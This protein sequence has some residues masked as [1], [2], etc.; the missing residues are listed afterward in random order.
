[1]IDHV[2][3]IAAA[4][5]SDALV[6]VFMAKSFSFGDAK[7]LLHDVAQLQNR[8]RRA[9]AKADQFK[10]AIVS[11]ADEMKSAE[12]TKALLELPVEDLN[13]SKKG[14]RT[15]LLR[16][17][18]Y[19]SIAHVCKAST[20]NLSSIY[21]I[22][23][24][25]ARDMKK[26]AAEYAR[27][28]Q[29]GVRIRLTSDS[30][31]REST[32]LVHAVAVYR[33][34]VS[35]TR[36]IDDNSSVNSSKI[37]YAQSDLSS[38]IGVRWLLSSK[39]KKARAEEAYATLREAYLGS[40]GGIQRSILKKL[41]EADEM[42]VESA[43]K[44]FE[45]DPVGF[46]NTIEKI[47]PGF[48]GSDKLMGYGLPEDLAL[49]IQ[50]ECF[51]PDGLLVELRNYQEWGVKY[52]LHQG[53]ALLGDEMGLGKTV[54]AIATM[55]SLKNT[56]ATHFVVVCPASVVANWC[57]EIA[58]K[59]RLRV[60]KVH[61]AKR[62]AALSSWL[63]NGGVAVTTYETTEHF[64]LRDSFRFSLLVVDEAH[65]VKNPGARRSCNVAKLSEHAD[66][67]LF[68]TGTALENNVEEMVSLI[69]L[70]RPDIA[71][72]IVG[73]THISSAARFKE[74]IAPVYYRRK[75]DDV[76]SELPELIESED[77]CS[78]SPEEES[79]YEETIRSRNMMAARR[80]SWNVEDVRK[81][82]KAQRLREIIQEGKED[83]RKMLVFSYFLDTLEKAMRAA[84]E[85]CY[86]PI[87]GSTPPQRRQEIIDE[88]DRAPAGSV[89]VA[90]IQSGGT[91]LN[92]QSASV[93]VICEPQFK[94]S[95]ENQAIS[96]AYRMGQTRNVMVHRLLC[97]DSVDERIVEILDE[98]RKLFAAFA[99]ESVAAKESLA[100]DDKEC[101]N[102]IEKEIERINAKQNGIS[103][104]GDL[105]KTPEKEK[106][107]DEKVCKEVLDFPGVSTPSISSV[108]GRSRER[109]ALERETNSSAGV[110]SGASVTRRVREYPQ[111]RGG[112]LNPRLF[113]MVQLGEGISELAPY[114][115]VVPGLVG[116]AVDY[117][118][119]FCTGAPARNAFEISHKG[120]VCVGRAYLF[121]DLVSR[122]AGL[123]DESIVSA[124]RLAAFDVAYRVG[125]RS[126]KPVEEIRPDSETIEN[127][128][129]MVKRSCRFL[130]DYG[131]KILD[132]L[133]FEGGYTDIVSASDGDFMTSDALWDFKVSKIPLNSNQTLQLLMY[134]RMGLHSIHPEFQQVKYL[135]IFNP[136]M[137]RV[138]RLPVG[139]IP[140]DVIAEV[141]GKIIG[142]KCES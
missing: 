131:P 96:R 135:G 124:I 109:G 72:K 12:L 90:Q 141:D 103:V 71:Q 38:V 77:W 46:S 138:Y 104:S 134:W 41:D 39:A 2:L 119:R 44:A 53:K 94:P 78:L 67:L 60:E 1:M 105:E 140:E 62:D 11:A 27:Q 42:S 126:Y 32:S 83:G 127:V 5:L 118:T 45:S 56:K 122:I 95:V 84:G 69:R 121:D 21:G 123:D 130:D 87:N 97:L 86:G 51:Y 49:Q 129:V 108:N 68:M 110:L 89:L 29:D 59:S 64:A 4:W 58:T 85:D 133:T 99:D 132:G 23:E 112:F 93:V 102:I 106:P 13:K 117:M 128:R 61:G 36:E 31:T 57:R 100:I 18:G 22:S 137:N 14:L 34:A 73:M 70:L 16:E 114:E 107:A 35:L 136:R 7:R 30:K 74:L 80:V 54:Q 43:W 19:T 66:R 75:R 120:A 82:T 91:G 25:A 92:I 79:V 37:E 47:A 142:Y 28:M 111:P 10:D 52:A 55:V 17:N 98:K 24:S 3:S 113:E 40:Y 125:V 76:L 115:N 6:E 50:E 81:S 33:R 63:K 8:V 48:L 101:S 26:I 65:Y 88:F 139:Q 116:I 20:S 15:S 9:P